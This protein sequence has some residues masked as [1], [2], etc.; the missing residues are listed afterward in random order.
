MT[1]PQSAAAWAAPA[2]RDPVHGT[3]RVP[4]SKSLTNRYLVL[5]AVAAG[6]TT[7]HRPLVSRDTLLMVGALRQLGVTLDRGDDSTWVLTPP[8]RLRGGGDVDCGL[9]G[10]VM[11]FV[12]PVA[13]L[14][15]GPVRFDGD[16]AA[17]TRPVAQLVGALRDLGVVVDAGG[18]DDPR[19][20]FTVAG[21]GS[22]TGGRVVIDASASSQFVSAL[23]LAGARYDRGLTL[24]HRGE[25]LPSRPHIDMTLQALA[26]VGVVVHEDAQDTWHVEPGPVQ[27][28]EVTIEPDLSSAAPFLAV[29]AAT[30]GRVTV[31]DWP[32]STTQAGDAMRELLSRMGA[33]VTLGP[34]GLTVTGPPRGEL[35]G[36]DHDLG[37]VGELT[38]VVAALCA[39]AS[40]PSRLRGVAHLRGHET[41]RLAA[42]ETEL[43]RIGADVTQTHDGLV[44]RPGRLRAATLQTYHDH[45]MA[46]AACLLG[47][48]VP[49][50]RVVDVATTGKTFPGF[51]ETWAGLVG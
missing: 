43:G 10:T 7:L 29:A 45:R 34:A 36:L 31:P 24:V 41:D 21:S 14:A 6:P 26:T 39:L 12:P 33:A 2:T 27:G 23:L 28:V 11:R 19:L 30:G 3:V 38:P 8:A 4:G 18:D 46:M 13:A 48:L 32:A 47:A 1:S 15:E 25:A 9:A 20:P 35:R 22:V 49:G 17:R 37:D 16:A 5:A 42:L 44:V 50:T 51:A 40:S